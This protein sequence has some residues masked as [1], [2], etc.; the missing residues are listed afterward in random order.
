MHGLAMLGSATVAAHEHNTLTKGKT[1]MKTITRTSIYLPV[2]AMLLT[3]ALAGPAMAAE[4]LVPFNGSLQAQESGVFQGPPPG[5]LLVDGSGGGI[6]TELGRFTLTWKFTVNLADGTGFGP[7][8]FITAN[9]D[10]IFTT[11]VGASEPT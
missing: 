1:D 3:A 2:A 8:H 5:T 7:V 6:A 11:T 9:G 4:K 10:D